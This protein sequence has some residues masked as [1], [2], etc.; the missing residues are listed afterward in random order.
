ME[1][2]YNADKNKLINK[3]GFSGLRDN[4]SRIFTAEANIAELLR[5]IK[6]E[7]RRAESMIDKMDEFDL[8]LSASP[9]GPKAT[10]N[11]QQVSKFLGA[12]PPKWKAIN[13]KFDRIK[14]ISTGVLPR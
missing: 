7:R 14:K 4:I 6:E 10:F 8:R 3:D 13:L 9:K 2:E 12:L 11:Q 1:L 5:Q